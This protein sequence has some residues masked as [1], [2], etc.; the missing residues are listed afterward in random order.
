MNISV[1]LCLIG[2]GFGVY[3]LATYFF[4]LKPNKR[5]N[6][7]NMIPVVMGTVAWMGATMRFYELPQFD[8]PVDFERAVLVASWAWLIMRIRYYR[9]ICHH[10]QK[11]IDK[12][13]RS[14]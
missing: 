4:V 6:P 7:K 1:I 10:Q 3:A 2:S 8:S 12:K 9:D 13:E 14:E 5:A 11:I